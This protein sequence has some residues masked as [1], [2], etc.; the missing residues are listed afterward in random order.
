MTSSTC[1]RHRRMTNQHPVADGVSLVAADCQNQRGA[2]KHKDTASMRDH[3]HQ[4]QCSSRS[5]LED[6]G[7]YTPYIDSA[8]L[9]T[10]FGVKHAT[11]GRG[12][13]PEI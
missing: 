2:I 13:R 8:R 7:P 11:T 12:L 1:M 9:Q 5:S 4:A 6:D 3:K 10:S